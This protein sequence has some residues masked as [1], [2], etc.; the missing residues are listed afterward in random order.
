MQRHGALAVTGL[1]GGGVIGEVAR[2]HVRIH[3]QAR[4]ALEQDIA[5]ELASQG[6]E[7][8]VQRMARALGT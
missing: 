2:Q 1:E 4:D 3:A 8:I 7:R 6:G 5:P